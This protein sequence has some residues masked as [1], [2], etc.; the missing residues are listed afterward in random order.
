MR[1]FPLALKTAEVKLDVSR[2]VSL[3]IVGFDHFPHPIG[4]GGNPVDM[5]AFA[6]RRRELGRGGLDQTAKLDQVFEEIGVETAGG[7][8]RQDV[9]IEE[10]PGL[11]RGHM[12]TGAPA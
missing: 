8:P 6:A 1:M 11:A 10:V 3:G 12:R 7:M 9:G 2:V 4:G 5:T